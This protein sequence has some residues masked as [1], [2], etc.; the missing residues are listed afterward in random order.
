MSEFLEVLLI[1]KYKV[2]ESLENLNKKYSIKLMS[3][4]KIHDN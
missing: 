1:I 3:R 4:G 2:D